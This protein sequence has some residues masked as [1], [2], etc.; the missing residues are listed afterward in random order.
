MFG[1]GRGIAAQAQPP[2]STSPI[3]LANLYIWLKAD[4]GVYS[5]VAMTTLAT[6]SQTVGG[7][8]DQSGNLRHMTQ[9]TGGARPTYLTGQQN[10]L[11]GIQFTSGKTLVFGASHDMT[12][13]TAYF[14]FY[15]SGGGST[16]LSKAGETK[17]YVGIG[18]TMDFSA[19]DG[20]LVSIAG[21]AYNQWVYGAVRVDGSKINS[22][23]MAQTSSNGVTAAH[24]I[25]DSIGYYGGSGIFNG[26]VAEV[27][28]YNTA[29]DGTT[30]AAIKSYLTTKYNL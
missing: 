20:T 1:V 25:F 17:N 30:M 28:V 27:I 11:P 9:N 12:A 2:R 29:H 22:Y 5:D 7:W 15:E 8:A 26:F 23:H 16:L 13:C 4:A 14:M 24:W 10:S 18:G 3:P 6:T 19:N 21:T